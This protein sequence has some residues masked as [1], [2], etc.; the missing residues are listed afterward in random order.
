MVN[1]AKVKRGASD[2]NT[3]A[4]IETSKYELNSQ[5]KLHASAKGMIQAGTDLFHAI[6]NL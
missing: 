2:A 5:D 4:V 1:E 3:L 6:K